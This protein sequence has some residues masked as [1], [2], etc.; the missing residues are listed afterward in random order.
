M[1]AGRPRSKACASRSRSSRPGTRGSPPA[2]PRAAAEGLSTALRLRARR[3]L[4]VREQDAAD[5][6]DRRRRGLHARVWAAHDQLRFD[7][8]DVGALVL[9]HAVTG[10]I[11]RI[12]TVDRDDRV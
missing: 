2:E 11:E 9:H 3:V 1:A 8:L 12:V 5:L 10:P 6:L 7:A 4:G